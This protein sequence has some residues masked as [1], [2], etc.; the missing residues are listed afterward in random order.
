MLELISHYRSAHPEETNPAFPPTSQGHFDHFVAYIEEHS[1]TNIRNTYQFLLKVIMPLFVFR[2]G[3]RRHNNILLTAGLK[4]GLVLFHTAHSPVYMLIVLHHLLV[5]SLLPPELLDFI[6]KAQCV[7]DWGEGH[8]FKLEEQN[9][10]AKHW[11]TYLTTEWQWILVYRNLL[12]LEKVSRR[13]LCLVSASTIGSLL[14]HSR[15]ECS[16]VREAERSGVSLCSEW[17]QLANQF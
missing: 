9:A 16:E 13:Y 7:G 6:V 15:S 5:R 12:D 11:L 2:A 8:D 14:H 4:H 10:V 1:N 3:L 17:S